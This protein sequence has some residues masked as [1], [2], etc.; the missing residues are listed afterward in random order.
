[1]VECGGLKRGLSCLQQASQAL[2]RIDVAARLHDHGARWCSRAC[3]CRNERQCARH[4][5]ART[6]QQGALC[7]P[8][9]PTCVTPR[10]SYGWI[11]GSAG[12]GGGGGD[13]VREGWHQQAG[14]SCG[15]CGLWPH[16]RGEQQRRACGVW[17]GRWPCERSG[18]QWHWESQ[19]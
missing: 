16:S 5:R 9:M 8:M 3:D 1:M 19:W 4:A 10:S 14:S 2:P 13:A 15:P 7:G 12:G 11:A 17:V 6:W 18:Q